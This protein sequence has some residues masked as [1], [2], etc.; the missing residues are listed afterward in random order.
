MFRSISVTFVLV[1][2][3][4]VSTEA[5]HADERQWSRKATAF[6]AGCFPGEWKDCQPKRI[7]SPDRRA[8]VQVSYEP[9]S[10]DP[11]IEIADLTVVRNGRTIGTIGVVGEVEDEIAWAPN[12]KALFISGNN[13]A[14]TDY[15]FAVY[16]VSDMSVEPIVGVAEQ[17][18]QD[19]VRSFPPCRAKNPINDCAD[20]TKQPDDYIGTAAIDWLSDSSG[21]V[22]MAE[23][24]CSSM[25]GGIMCQTLGYE[26]EIPSGKILRRMEPRE[27]ATRWQRSM[28]WKFDIPG[29]PEYS[30]KA[31]KR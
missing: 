29:P 6:M 9:N 2:L 14:N 20:L 3:I 26:I 28:A 21:I 5:A 1:G 23:V 16:R 22:I 31:T 17:A 13:N 11:A 12:S 10:L 24:T 30:D 27:F 15:H 8:F 18:L 25:M 19:M 4:A 7:A